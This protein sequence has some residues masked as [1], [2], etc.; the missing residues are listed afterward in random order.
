[1]GHNIAAASHNIAAASHYNAAASHSMPFPG[2]IPNYNP[3]EIIDNI[4]K[5][6]VGEEPDTL[7]PW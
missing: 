6:M 7:I 1:M 5:L 2:T 4:R 3:R